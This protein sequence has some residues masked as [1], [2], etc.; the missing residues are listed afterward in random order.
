MTEVLTNTPPGFVLGEGYFGSPLMVV[1]EAPGQEERE[2]L[3]PFVGEDGQ[4][5]RAMLET[6][7]VDETKVWFTNVYKLELPNL[8][9]SPRLIKRHLKYL[10]EEIIEGQP[11][12]IL[13]L[14]ET[15]FHTLTDSTLSINLHRGI[16][17]PLSERIKPKGVPTAYDVR[18]KIQLIEPVVM[19]TYHPSYILRNRRAGEQ[20]RRDIQEWATRSINP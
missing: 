10:Q 20:W 4:K 9:P 14:G 8:Q 18:L 5:F 3:R 13:A 15:A 17:H 16:W 6:L 12:Y 1:G 11:K 7:G 2:Q 19:P